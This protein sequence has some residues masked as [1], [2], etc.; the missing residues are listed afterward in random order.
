M[1]PRRRPVAARDLLK[2]VADSKASAVAHGFFDCTV[3]TAAPLPM[4][5]EVAVSIADSTGS[6]TYDCGRHSRWTPVLG[7]VSE[8]ID[9]Q[10]VPTVFGAAGSTAS[11]LP[12]LS[13][14][15][16]ARI[17]LM[18]CASLSSQIAD[19]LKRHGIFDNTAIVDD[20]LNCLN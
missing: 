9:P 6:T 3:E 5:A 7:V 10:T 4:E 12:G 17:D 15:E 14:S 8:N 18:L 11:T 13:S 2:T 19:V 1:Q 16:P 20:I